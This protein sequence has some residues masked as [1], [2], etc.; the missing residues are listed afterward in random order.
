MIKNTRSYFDNHPDVD[1]FYFT[2]DGYAFFT[3]NDAY[4]HTENLNDKEIKTITR[5]DCED[6]ETDELDELDAE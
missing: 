6:I 1:T 5:L 4:N 3:E 2:A